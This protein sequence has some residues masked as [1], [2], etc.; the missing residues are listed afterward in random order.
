MYQL[1]PTPLIQKS[2]LGHEPKL[3]P[4]L[5]MDLMQSL[6]C[7]GILCAGTQSVSEPRSSEISSNNARLTHLEIDR[8]HSLLCLSSF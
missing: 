3:A 1:G 5:T 4:D 6:G 2:V 7:S 8:F